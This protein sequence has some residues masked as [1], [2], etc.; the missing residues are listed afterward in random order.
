MKF[1]SLIMWVSQ[2]GLSLVFPT[3]ALLGLGFWLHNRFD[4]GVWIVLLCGVVGFL[5]SVSTAKSCWKAM[6]KEAFG[7]DSKDEPP[8]AFN[9]NS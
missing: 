2:F 1:L 5:T 7:S 8:V 4:V 6:Q 9:N 3:L